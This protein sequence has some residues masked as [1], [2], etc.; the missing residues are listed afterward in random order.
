MGVHES[1]SLFWERMIHQSREFWEWATPLMHKHFPHTSA[2]TAD[3]FYR[4]VNQVRPDWIR[5][6]ADE[7]TYPM[8]IILRFELE[9][10]MINNSIALDDLPRLWNK[11]MK[12]SLNVD[13]TDDAHGVLQDVHW[14]VN[15]IGYFPSYTLGAMIAAQLFESLEKEMPDVRDKIRRGEFQPIREWLKQKIHTVGSLYPSPDELLVHAT[16]KPMDPRIFAS[17]L[18]NKYA[19]LYDLPK[20]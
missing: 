12:D 9:Q 18:K 11:K 2:C 20:P 4:A 5:T 1:Q 14:G 19:D 3:D 10:G 8:H 7:V 15:A 6:Q 17:Y 13:V 16:G